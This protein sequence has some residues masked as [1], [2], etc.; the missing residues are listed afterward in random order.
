MTRISVI[1]PL[2]LVA[3]SVATPACAELPTAATLLTDLG[4]TP[5]QIAEVQAG[6]LV[7]GTTQP[8]GP[9]E[10][11]SA[12]AFQVPTSPADLV[13]G[14]KQGLF[15]K[16][17]PGTIA[18][19]FVQGT[20]SPA[21]FAK[22]NF[23]ADAMGRAAAYVKAQPGGPLNL[24]AAEMASFQ[25][26]GADASPT[27][28]EQAV[29]SA[30]LARMQAYQALGLAGIAPYVR[31]DGKTRSPADELRSASQALRTLQK[32][33]PRA[34]AMLLEYPNAKPLGTEE[35][36]RWTYFTAQNVPTIAL[37]HSL[38]IPDG[39]AWIGVQRQ[40]YVSEGYNSEQAIG[41][42]LPTQ[43][44]TVVVYANHTST[45]Q[46]EGFGGG[47]KRS[48]GSRVLASQLESLFEKVRRAAK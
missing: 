7:R 46:I 10:L 4:Y 39:A 42:M 38:F 32:Y 25:K 27:E 47:V 45:D 37:T 18:F 43:S 11:V 6:E 26:L 22:F 35:A 24:S 28:V 19:A 41:A 16:V 20:G 17:G 34:Y 8:G 15:D 36:F 9:R 5:D 3:G 29:V 13:A 14:I 48:I 31:E 21:D 30:L 12:F 1:V 33:A 44:G 40:Y 23:G 2:L